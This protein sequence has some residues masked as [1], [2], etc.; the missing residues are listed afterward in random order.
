MLR[1]WE[2]LQFPLSK[3]PGR[4]QSSFRYDKIPES[5]ALVSTLSLFWFAYLWSHSSFASL[6]SPLR[7]WLNLQV[8]MTLGCWC[9]GYHQQGICD[10]YE[11]IHLELVM[12]SP[13]DSQSVPWSLLHLPLSVPLKSLL[14]SFPILLLQGASLSSGRKKWVTLWVPSHTI[15]FITFEYWLLLTFY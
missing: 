14:S 2:S 9:S 12:F 13:T 1:S 7:M 4:T 3:I 11:L 15:N 10:W 6:C 5:L 8:P